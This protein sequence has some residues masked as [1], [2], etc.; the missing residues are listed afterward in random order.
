MKQICVRPSPRNRSGFTLIELLVVIAIIAILAAM[1]LPALAAAKR[2]AQEAVCMSNIKQLTLANILY[3]ND[4]TYFVQTSLATDPYGKNAEWVG[5][6]FSY[7][8]KSTNLIVCPTA[9]TEAP[10]TI[11]T[12]DGLYDAGQANQGGA[13]N[14]AY[15]RDLDGTF[16]GI[17]GVYLQ[18]PV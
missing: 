18:L 16:L 12:A 17:S 13:A 5:N 1:L 7:F 11:A 8:A 10:A 3:A 14:Y 9:A 4:Y 6:M 15:R 2:R